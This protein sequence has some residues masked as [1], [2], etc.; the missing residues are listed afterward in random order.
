MIK[1]LLSA[2]VFAFVLAADAQSVPDPVAVGQCAEQVPFGQPKS[3]KQ[4]TTVIC[5]KAYVLEHDN[6]AKIPAWVSYTLTPEHTTGCVTRSNAFAPDDSLEP[7]QRSTL[8][9]YAKSG[10]DIGHQANDGDMS[11]DVTV[12]RQSFLL[13]NMAPQLPGFNRG[14]WKK[15]EDQTRAFAK[16]R[17]HA[18]LIYVGPIYSYTQ[19]KTIGNGVVV[20]HAFFKI[21]TDL[22]THEVI[23]TEFDHE[24]SK[25]ALNTFITSLAQVQKDTGIVFPMP[26]DAN[27]STDMWPS[28]TKSVRASKGAV[29]SLR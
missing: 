23:V 21:I 6:K 1:Y 9:D 4:N 24:S 17:N 2:L 5:R 8:K 19:D 13:S 29:C 16:N 26:K 7:E 12:E 11:W 25:A 18:L 28:Q 10:Y 15:L 20:P 3:P 14:I 22:E 27:Y